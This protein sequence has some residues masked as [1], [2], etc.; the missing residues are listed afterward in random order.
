[1][2]RPAL[3]DLG[4]T[5]WDVV[6]VGAG[7]VGC[8]SARELAGRGFKVLLVDRGD[9]GAGT[10]SRSSR[11]LYSG[12]GYLA[13]R[14]PLWQMVLHPIDMLQRLLY[15][16]DV[17]R[18]RAELAQQMPQHLTRHPFT[19]PFRKGD[20]YPPWLVDTGFRLVEAL[21]G[22]KV[23]L[24]YRRVAPAAAAE[25]CPL[26]AGLGTAPRSIGL[27]EEYMYA[28]PER[29]CVDTALDAEARGATLRTYT[30]VAGI[31]QQDGGWIV[32]LQDA[33]EPDR[34]PVHATCDMVINAA[35]P[36]VDRLTG[37]GGDQTRRIVGIKG[38]NVMV[39][40]PD[41]WR[42]QGLE[43]FSSKGEPYY[44]FPWRDHH[45]IGP[46][47]THVTDD[48]DNIRVLDEEI[49]YIL[50]EANILFPDLGLTRADVLHTWCGV[51]PVT[52]TDGTTPR[53]LVRAVQSPDAP[54]LV[55]MTGSTIMLHR[56]AGRLAARAVER[57]MGRRG[58]APTG[59]IL[60][61]DYDG[62][63]QRLKAEHVVHLTDLIRR[64]LP[65][66]LNPDLGRTRAEELSHIAAAALG[67][68]EAQRLDELR[69]FAEDTA[70]V[71]ASTPAAK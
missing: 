32:S 42:G 6:V 4:Q 52:S 2:P 20:R 51:R 58:P 26:A 25:D 27:F 21:G 39:K 31:A 57:H 33:L 54:G 29:I 69:L 7:A 36:W 35:G 68:N 71:Y 1:M 48:P 65:D 19:Y 30:R 44:V 23:P 10:S 66:G 60:P 70:R 59:T 45:F 5:H 15:T 50:S 28:W 40:L 53:N 24:S 55:T 64:R 17:M 14:Y 47:E 37:A 46:T 11:M 67:W 12:L 8:A 38:V 63:G 9:I 62:I 18:C 56:H 3:H 61:P 13:V 43:A 49:D 41:A 16:R 22:W 34:A